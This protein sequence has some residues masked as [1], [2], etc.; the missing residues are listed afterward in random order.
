M[1]DPA[2]F[3][4]NFPVLETKSYLNAGTEGPLP[5]RV[6]DVIDARVQYELQ[7]RSGKDYVMAGREVNAK[8]R[9]AYARVLNCQ[10]TEIALTGSTTDGCSTILAGLDLNPGD[11]VITSDEEHPGLLAPLGRLKRKGIKVTI[12]PFAEIADAVSADT[13]LVAVSHVSWV[14]GQVVDTEAL[15]ATGV[16]FLLDGAQSIGAVRTDVQELGCAYFAGSGQKWL[17]GPQGSGCLYVAP[18]YLDQ[19]TPPWPCYFTVANVLDSLDSPPSANVQRLDVDFPPV[20]RSA[21]ATASMSVFEEA[22]W[23]WAQARATSQA[24]KLAALLAAR[25]LEVG[26]RGHSTLVSWKS[27]DADAEVLRLA[28]QHI[29]VRSIPSHG[30]VR[31]S[32]GAWTADHELDQLAEAA[33]ALRAA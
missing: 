8:A 6:R 1:T 15:K 16:P 17:C 26:P 4:A 23:D 14:S 22:G 27:D 2:A 20:L 10:S 9:A 5:E 12:A 30:Y 3:R 11:E 32:V 19:I 18:D 31:A 7:G 33:A 24:A 21:W 13:R 29:V 28:E 25:D